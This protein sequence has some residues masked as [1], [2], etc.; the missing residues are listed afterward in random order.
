[1]TQTSGNSFLAFLGR[2][3]ATKAEVYR[4]SPNG[5]VQHDFDRHDEAAGWLSLP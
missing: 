2:V 4:Q 3:A 1:V 5:D